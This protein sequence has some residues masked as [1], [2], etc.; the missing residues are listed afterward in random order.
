MK[1]KYSYKLFTA[2]PGRKVRWHSRVF[3]YNEKEIRSDFCRF[4]F[5][6]LSL[7]VML[8]LRHY[9][10]FLHLPASMQS[11]RGAHLLSLP[12][13]RVWPQITIMP[14]QT[15]TYFIPSFRIGEPLILY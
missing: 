7:S 9:C 8:L 5:I 2:S 6:I 13:H 14:S 4:S 1:Y 11:D 12:Y 3:S 15:D 10:L